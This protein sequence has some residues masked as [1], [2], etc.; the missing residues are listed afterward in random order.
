MTTSAREYPSDR[1]VLF[2]RVLDA[3]RALVW[4]VWSDVTHLH[5]WWGPDGFTTTTHQFEFVPG[6]VWR[7][8]M[9]GPDGTDYRTRIVF[10]EIVEPSRI[11]YENSWDL[12]GAPLDFTC[13]TTFDDAESRKTKLAFRMTFAD[14]SAFKTAVERYGVLEGGTQ[15]FERLNDFVKAMAS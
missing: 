5:Q 14:V 11:V 13:V 10:R 9:H 4:K 3:P 7:F 6:G 12:P 1:E 2:T 8:V 15:T